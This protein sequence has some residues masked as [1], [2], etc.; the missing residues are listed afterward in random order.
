MTCLAGIAVSIIQLIKYL[1]IYPFSWWIIG[2]ITD[3]IKE[4]IICVPNI[5]KMTIWIDNSTHVKKKHYKKTV[6]MNYH[7]KKPTECDRVFLNL[8]GPVLVA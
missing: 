4:I 2:K 5:G 1:L 7:Q 3:L 8:Y 6:N